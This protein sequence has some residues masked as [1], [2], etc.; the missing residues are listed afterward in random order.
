MSYPSE[1]WSYLDALA[2]IKKHV[3]SITNVYL[4]HVQLKNSWYLSLSP[5]GPWSTSTL[6]T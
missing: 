6:D 2:T 3:A 1:A 5:T 4:I